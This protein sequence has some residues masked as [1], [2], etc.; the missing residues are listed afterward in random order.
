MVPV[1]EGK[2]E[3]NNLKIQFLMSNNLAQN[4]DNGHVVGDVWQAIKANQ[5][6]MTLDPFETMLANMGYGVRESDGSY[7]YQIPTCRT[8]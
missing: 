3:P 2:L 8:S 1:A 6:R 7:Y 5:E 4:K